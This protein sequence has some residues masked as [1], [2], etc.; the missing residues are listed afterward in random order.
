MSK[1]DE[2][3]LRESGQGILPLNNSVRILCNVGSLMNLVEITHLRQKRQN[4][5]WKETVIR[6][7][8]WMM[9][10]SAKVHQ[11]HKK[12]IIYIYMKKALHEWE[13]DL[14]LT[15]INLHS[16]LVTV[17]VFILLMQVSQTDQTD[18]AA[19]QLSCI[20]SQPLSCRDQSAPNL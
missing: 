10:P 1:D 19:V 17:G 12:N 6:L 16:P 2:K 20:I 13:R 9:H 18:E 11:Y 4:D 7:P 8:V 3:W 14:W 5:E 15:V